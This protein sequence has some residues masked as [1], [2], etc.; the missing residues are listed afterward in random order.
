MNYTREGFSAYGV[1]E[2]P[3]RKF[4]I[5]SKPKLVTH[6]N[7]EQYNV[8]CFSSACTVANRPVLKKKKKNTGKKK[9]ISFKSIQKQQAHQTYL[10]IFILLFFFY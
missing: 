1:T 9:N 7:I 4:Q 2:K 3:M 5:K 6:S 8:Y 10:G